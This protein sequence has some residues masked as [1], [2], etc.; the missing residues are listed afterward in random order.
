MRKKMR[1][2]ISSKYNFIIFVLIVLLFSN[3]TFAQGNQL[4]ILIT[5]FYGKEINEIRRYLLEPFGNI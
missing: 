3:I 4:E 2:Y 5:D 1:S